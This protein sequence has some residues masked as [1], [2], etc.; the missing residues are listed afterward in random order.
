MNVGD[1]FQCVG[2]GWF[3]IHASLAWCNPW[4]CE[5]TE[6]L[7]TWQ[8]ILLK[9]LEGQVTPQIMDVFK[10]IVYC[11]CC[12]EAWTSNLYC[13]P[14]VPVYATPNNKGSKVQGIVSQMHWRIALTNEWLARVQQPCS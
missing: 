5:R 1:I 8:I 3:I 11:R 7:W 4:N 10:W 14:V 6:P 9:I 13:I 2:V 12:K